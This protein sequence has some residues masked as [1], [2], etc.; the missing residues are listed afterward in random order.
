MG[1][2]D[3]M[4]RSSK[5]NPSHP[6]DPAL[7]RLFGSTNTAAGVRVT[8]DT[9]LQDAAVYAAV[10]ALSEAVASLPLVL[11]RRRKDGGS[12]RATDH[13][14]YQ[15]AHDLPNRNQTSFEFRQFGM[16]ALLLRG[17]FVARKVSTGGRGL[18]ALEPLHPDGLWIDRDRLTGKRVYEYSP[19]DGTT[20]TLLADEVV[21]VMGMPGDDIRGL[22]PI[23]HHRETIGASLGA[24]EFGARLF[25]NNAKPG[26]VLEVSGKLDDEQAKKL[27]ERWRFAQERANRVA[28]LEDGVKFNP[29]T[30]NPQDAQFLETR[31]YTRSEIAAIFRVPPHKIGDLERATFSNI[32]QQA[33]EFVTDSLMP[34][35]VRWEQALWRDALTESERRAG[36]FFRFNVAGLLR[37]DAKARSDYYRAMFGIGALNQ[38]EIRG[39][40]EMNPIPAGDTYYVPLNM[41]DADKAKAMKA[42]ELLNGGQE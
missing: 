26:G 34:W 3:A 33:L 29:I 36:Y 21:H 27:A 16:V 10:A 19:P 9:A 30:I 28:V 35:L 14:L 4:F 7:A 6:K 20:F 1:F 31:K 18:A 12:D 37:G 13:P 40:E 39:L 8:A 24:K 2:L 23:E 38:N 42:Q 41:V 22:N 5:V 17:N 15:L 32:E 11:Y 25:A